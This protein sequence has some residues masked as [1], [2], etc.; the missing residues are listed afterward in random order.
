MPIHG[1]EVEDG[2]LR[3]YGK[4]KAIAQGRKRKTVREYLLKQGRFAHFTDE[5]IEY[6]QKKMAPVT[7]R[8]Y[9]EVLG[10]SREA[11]D[12]DIKKALA[13]SEAEL[14]SPN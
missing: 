4:S 8:D 1:D 12:D 7:K 5:D 6:F 2:A 9:Y 13:K 3:F 11:S 10:V 14:A